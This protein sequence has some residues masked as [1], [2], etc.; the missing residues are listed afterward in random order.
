MNDDDSARREKYE[1]KPPSVPKYG[2]QIVAF[3]L[4]RLKVTLRGI[5]LPSPIP[6]ACVCA[7]S[8]I[9]MH[10]GKESQS[11]IRVVGGDLEGFCFN[12]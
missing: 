1:A 6:G 9:R 7:A 2:L 3:V 12:S 5:S 8:E 11:F 4:S 10:H